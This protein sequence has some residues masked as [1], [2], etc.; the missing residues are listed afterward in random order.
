MLAAAKK[1]QKIESN[2][3]RPSVASAAAVLKVSKPGNVT[4]RQALK[5]VG[6][7]TPFAKDKA[8][9]KRV[10]R[11][12][13]Q[14]ETPDVMAG[15][16]FKTRVPP[17]PQV[18]VVQTNYQH[19][20]DPE[21]SQIQKL[22]EDVK[23][24][25]MRLSYRQ[26]QGLLK[27][28]QEEK[29]RRN[30]LFKGVCLAWKEELEK[31]AAATNE[32]KQ[33]RTI[34]PEIL[35]NEILE[36][37]GVKLCARSIRNYGKN[38]K[39]GCDPE[40]RGE[41]GRIPFRYY[42]A[43]CAAVMTFNSLA[44][45]LGTVAVDR[46]RLVRMVN[47][48]VNKKEGPG[49]RNNR[50]LFERIQ[51]DTSD[52]MEIGKP[53]RVEQE[54][55]RNRWGTFYQLNLWYDSLKQFLIDQGFGT[56]NETNV[57]EHGEI[58]W[59][60]ETQGKRLWNIDE[61]AVALDN[62]ANGKGGRPAASFYNPRLQNTATL[63]AHKSSYHC[64]L[65]AGAFA[66]GEKLPE[67]FQLPTDAENMENEG[68]PLEFIEHMHE[69]VA[70]YLDGKEGRHSNTYGV[71]KK[72]GMNATQFSEYIQNNVLPCILADTANKDG[73]RSV[74][75]VD[76]GPGRGNTDMLVDCA[77]V[78]VHLFPSGPPNTTHI[79]QARFLLLLLCFDASSSVW[80]LPFFSHFVLLI[81][82]HLLG[83]CIR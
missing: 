31:K 1:K 41:K 42:K 10:Y 56:A 26:K 80:R 22:K 19:T 5:L 36:K 16:N 52:T 23:K 53:N 4:V 17:T 72:G 78:G 3:R 47:A 8:L 74:G 28:Q 38:G 24:A 70:E 68:L 75:L 15:C 40:Q 45:Q 62:T 7:D 12:R 34:S 83:C 67:H 21:L 82:V 32:G 49:K 54:Q 29:K 64:T 77:I 9:Q 20:A 61:T 81:C 73:K 44:S 76:G 50:K 30:E 2:G 35:V 48:C 43:L 33:Y 39:L 13:D 25:N 27:S 11:Q 14:L 71:N 57:E 60:D 46:P 66:S 51:R 37:E 63:A 18:V 6:Y 59:S 69:T 55:R 65:L 79:L 58:L